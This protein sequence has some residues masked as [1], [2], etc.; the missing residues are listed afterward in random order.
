[1]LALG[2]FFFAIG[3]ALIPILNVELYLIG[4]SD[5]VPHVEYALIASAG[6]TVGKIIWFYAGWNALKI[7]WL[8]KK[9]ESDSWKASYAKWHARI[10]G[11]PVFA[12]LICL[13]SAASGFP[14][15]AVM[16]VL[17]GALRM[18]FG[19]FVATVFVGRAIR[20]YVCL[21][22]GAELWD[23]TGHL[24]DLFNF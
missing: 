10:V 18:N 23:V 12:G 24:V 9:M 13:A 4:I 11:R 7:R 15:L 20:F 2:S 3:S 21:A 6:Q 17:F 16:A 19:V 1:M 22:T 14:P 8:A 5:Q